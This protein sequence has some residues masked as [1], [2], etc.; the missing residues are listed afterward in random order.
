MVW[1]RACGNC[2]R[3]YLREPNEDCKFCGYGIS[4]GSEDFE[5]EGEIHRRNKIRLEVAGV[6]KHKGIGYK[7]FFFNNFL[8]I[9]ISDMSKLE[10][11]RLAKREIGKLY[12]WASL[13]SGMWERLP[14]TAV[15]M[16]EPELVSVECANEEVLCPM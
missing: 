14:I 10:N 11:K 7:V 4:L 8:G 16:P 9:P 3:V 5:E 13:D 15:V 6:W 2:L 12:R 1:R